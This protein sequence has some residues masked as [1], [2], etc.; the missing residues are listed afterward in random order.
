MTA[1]HHVPSSATGASRRPW[2]SIALPA[3]LSLVPALAHAET[4]RL[5]GDRVAIYNLIGECRVES[6]SGPAVEI[7]V[8]FKGRDAARLKAET[9]TTSGRAAL[10]VLYPG[11]SFVY[12]EMGSGSS[13]TLTV[14]KDGSIGG[15]S[16]SGAR[17]VT[18]RG[19]GE[20]LQAWA[21]I[22]VR[23]PKGR[24]LEVRHGVGELSATGV[25]GTLS[26]DTA[27]GPVRAERHRGALSVD[28]G[29]G[30]VE[31]REVEGEVKIDTGSGA[32]A[33]ADLSGREIDVDTGS[34]AVQG[35]RLRADRLVI[36]TGS[37][38]IQ[39][40]GVQAAVLRL[41]TGSGGVSVGL[42]ADVEDA[43]VDSGSGS[44][45]VRV[46]RSLGAMLEVETGSG[47]IDLDAE[48]SDL[49][50]GGGEL[51]A[52]LGDGRGRLRIDTGSGG[53]RVVQR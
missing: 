11:N 45:T 21:D 48:A 50:K 35:S 42:D 4:F 40:E 34:G 14:Q 39:L 9:G 25:D 2:T 8:E 30:D 12:P 36:D 38:A 10:R 53:V 46:P 28:T 13:T 5:E 23:V 1:L 31:V 18:I 27:S 44:V 41:D 24:D 37:G 32:V 19:R 22:V 6:G 47:G 29:S 26:L 15:G 43:Q 20:G 49:R 3:L 51:S 16:G 17:K 7:V 52:R 33:L